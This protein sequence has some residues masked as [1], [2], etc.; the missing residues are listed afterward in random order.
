MTMYVGEKKARLA[1][2]PGVGEKRKAWCAC[3]TWVSTRKGKGITANVAKM[4][5]YN[6]VLTVAWKITMGFVGRGCLGR[7]CVVRVILDD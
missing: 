4:N 7:V 6:K 1:G 3:L 2:S 5:G